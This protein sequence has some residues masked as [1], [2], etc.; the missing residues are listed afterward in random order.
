ME[1][2]CNVNDGPTY[3]LY[4]LSKQILYNLVLVC[5]RCRLRMSTRRELAIGKVIQNARHF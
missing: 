1:K 2:T 5:Y 4:I 3:T